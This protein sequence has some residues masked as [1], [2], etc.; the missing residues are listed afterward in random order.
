[1]ENFG[2]RLEGGELLAKEIAG[3]EKTLFI[4]GNGFDI[5]HGVPSRFSDFSKH[6]R[7]ED[8][9]LHDIV[10]RFL[11]VQE[12]WSDLEQA[13]AALDVDEIVDY[14]SMFLM[15]YGAEDWSDAGHHDYQYE[16]ERIIHS[17][18]SSLKAAFSTWVVGLPIPCR[19]QVR[20]PVCID[21]TSTFLTFN[22]T[23]TLSAVYDVPDTHVLFIHGKAGEDSDG[24]V[25]GHAWNPAIIPSLNDVPDPESMD[26]RVMEGNEIINDFFGETFK[27]TKSIIEANVTFFNSLK[28]ITKIYVLG[29]SLSFIDKEY[30]VTIVNNIDLANVSWI[31]TYYGDAEIR[32]HREFMD[33]LGVDQSMTYYVLLNELR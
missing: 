22:Y 23:D 31:I 11:P 21:P 19:S 4:I 17:L 10:E 24:L 3:M 8:S 27:D 14:A 16:V 33:G 5:H 20:A 7:I 9:S 18:S 25:L 2:P 13:L 15:S 12:D 28:D 30:F 32:S 6:L 26:T 29:H 1:M